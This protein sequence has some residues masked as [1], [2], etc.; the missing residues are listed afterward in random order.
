MKLIRMLRRV[1]VALVFIYAVL[2][3]GLMLAMRQPPETFGAIVAKLP[4]AVFMLVPFQ[5]L[6]MR[7]RTG[8]LRVGEMAPNFTLKTSDLASSVQLSKFREQRPVVLVFG[9]YT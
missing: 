2:I 8:T 4:P 9:S 1:A 5:S 6:W 7:A 3:C